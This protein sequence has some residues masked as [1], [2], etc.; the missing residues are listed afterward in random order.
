MYSKVACLAL[1]VLACVSLPQAFAS[2]QE[3][4]A[5][6]GA[7]VAVSIL[8]NATC[9]G[10]GMLFPDCKQL[11]CLLLVHQHHVVGPTSTELPTSCSLG[12]LV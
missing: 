5:P 1:L 7:N 4:V 2:E 9:V 8:L 11:L 12:R 6:F 3:T 10:S